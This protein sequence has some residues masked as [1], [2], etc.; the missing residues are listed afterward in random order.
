MYG[1]GGDI[2]IGSTA[3]SALVQESATQEALLDSEVDFT[4]QKTGAGRASPVKV[5]AK[6]EDS[7]NKLLQSGEIDLSAA[8]D[9][10]LNVVVQHD[11]ARSEFSLPLHVVQL[12]SRVAVRWPYIGFAATSIILL[13]IYFWR[14][15]GSAKHRRRT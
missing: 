2:P 9:W 12:Q 7:E 6:R 3:F 13:M 8:G 15:S 10:S 1:P 4:F 11:A 5:R 14:H